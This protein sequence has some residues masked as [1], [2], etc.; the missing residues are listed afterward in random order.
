MGYA[1]V[2]YVYVG[3]INVLVLSQVPWF[4]SLEKSLAFKKRQTLWTPENQVLIEVTFNY[5]FLENET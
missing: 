5:K 3:Q 4:S 2:P 1:E